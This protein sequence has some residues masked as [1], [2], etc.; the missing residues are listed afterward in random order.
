MNCI[1]FIAGASSVSD[2]MSYDRLFRKLSRVMIFDLTRWLILIV[3]I[4]DQPG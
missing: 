2:L 3:N 4:T 1:V